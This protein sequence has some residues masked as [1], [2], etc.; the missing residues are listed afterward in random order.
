MV[1]RLDSRFPLV[2]RTPTSVQIGVSTPQVVFERLTEPVEHMLA[3]LSIGVTRSGITMIGRK[4]GAS[5]GEISALL[6][7][8]AP[9]LASPPNPRRTPTVVLVGVGPTAERIAAVLAAAGVNL[10]LAASAT[11]AENEECE[12][13]IAVGH[14][15]LQPELYGLW[16][17]RDLPHLPVVLSDTEVAIGPVV[18][19]GSGPCLYCLHRH[20][21]DADSAWPAMA[22][23]LFG[24]RSPS[25][26][27]IVASEV[28]AIVARLTL[29]RLETGAA[30]AHESIHIDVATGS[31]TTKRWSRHPS[32]GCEVAGWTNAEAANAEAELESPTAEAPPETDSA[33][34]S[35]N[36]RRRH[37]RRWPP[38][39][40]LVSSGRG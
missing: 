19:P 27:E 31:L 2:W 10:R 6:A 34:V 18:E 23:Q 8:L 9:V 15:V 14:F 13:A 12:F 22:T 11:A 40:V 5:A 37:S 35:L 26:D 24:R 7:D 32:C 16:L 39:K 25:D 28:A 33:A 29:G 17:R 21:T 3:A 30:F 4:A 1:L 36:G 38:K 20:S